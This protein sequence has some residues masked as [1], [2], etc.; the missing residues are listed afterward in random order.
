[1]YSFIV[2]LCFTTSHS[3]LEIGNAV[4]LR[5][6]VLNDRSP[7]VAIFLPGQP[8]SDRNIEVIFPEH[9]TAIRH[10]T[11][12]PEHL[13][14]FTAPKQKYRAIWRHSRDSVEYERDVEGGV[15]LLA[16]AVLQEDGVLFHY[17]FVNRSN[18]AYDVIYSVTDPRLSGIFSDVRMERTYVHHKDGFELLA[19]ET[20]QRLT[21][22][23]TQWLPSRL[24]ASF[25]W[26]V[27]VQHVQKQEDGTTF[28]YK[29]LPVDEPL[30]ATVSTDHKW[31]VA[32]FTRTTGN[33]WSNP[34][35]TCQHVDPQTSVAAGQKA[36]VEMKVIVLRATLNE[37]LQRVRAQRNVLV[38]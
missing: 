16:R 36:T 25:T 10:G 21:M 9:V 1:M 32:S 13:Y 2:V 3:K 8:D 23:L 12:A 7:A 35:L 17:E 31:I 24:L 28:Y 19:S 4:G 26:P 27:P 37:I 34:E 18:V 6:L 22:S 20:P 29:S 30:I 33:V 14:M 5:L 15:H 11:S 38:P